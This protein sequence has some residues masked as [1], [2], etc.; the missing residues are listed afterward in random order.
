MLSYFISYE[1]IVLYLLCPSSNLHLHTRKS[2][3]L[4]VL[5]ES[6]TETAV[7]VIAFPHS[8]TSFHPSRKVWVLWRLLNVCL[9][10]LTS[11]TTY[12]GDKCLWGSVCMQR[13]H[14]VSA[15]QSQLQGLNVRGL[16]CPPLPQRGSPAPS[17]SASRE[18]KRMGTWHYACV[19]SSP[20]DL[21]ETERKR[22]EQARER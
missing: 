7:Q 5:K 4:L 11:L 2:L 17:G 14:T 20:K 18:A 21:K 6:C 19:W 13:C 12:A 3:D 8:H 22:E 1:H 9:A 15:T 16:S 10:P